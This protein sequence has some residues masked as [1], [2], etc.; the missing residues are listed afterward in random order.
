MKKQI[1][2]CVALFCASLTYAADI[3]LA[4]VDYNIDTIQRLI[5]GPGCEY[6]QT[7]M[8]QSSDGKK[9]LDV[10]FLFVDTHNPY[11]HMEQVLSYDKLIGTECPTA[12]LERK[13]TSTHVVVG[14]TNADFFVTGSAFDNGRPIGLTIGNSEYAYV[15]YSDYN[16]ELERRAAGVDV[17]G[18]GQFAATWDYTGSLVLSDT[19]LDIIRVNYYR[20]ENEL[21]LFNHHRGTS[22]E[23]NEYGTEVVAVLA[24]GEKWKTNGSVQLVVK[25]VRKN[26]GN[27]TLTKDQVVLSGHGTKAA[28][29]NTLKA[30]DKVVINFTLLFNGEGVDLAQCAGGDNYKLIVDNGTPVESKKGVDANGKEIELNFW[31]ELHPRTGFG[32][33][34]NRDTLVMC[35]VDGRTT[36]SI[37]CTTQVLGE[38]MRHYG[39][40]YALNWDGGGS[41][42]MAINHFGQV[43]YASSNGVERAVGNGMF[44]VADVPEDDQT[45][46]TL[47]PYETHF[48]VPPY[49]MY[50]PK[51][52]GYNK[53]GI[54]ISTDVKDVVLSCDESLGEIRNNNEFIASGTQSGILHATAGNGTA[55]IHISFIAEAE[56]AFRL[57]SVL[58]DDRKS[59]AV[60]VSSL[61]GSTT[62]KV[63]AHV[64]NWKSE[65]ENICTVNAEGEIVAVNN[66]V[67]TVVGMLGSFA[68][69]I[70]VRVQFPIARD[71]L[72]E[73]FVDNT[74]SWNIKASPASFAPTFVAPTEEN[75]FPSLQFTGKTTRSPYILLEKDIPLYGL[76]DSIRIRFSTDAVIEKFTLT[77]HANNQAESEFA[78]HIFEP[79]PTNVD[80]TLSIAISDL[81]D[82]AD[83]AIYPIWM[84]SLRFALSTKLA[85]G[86]YNIVWK[87]IELYYDG[88]A[89]LTDLDQATLPTWVV[90]PNPVADGVLQVSNLTVGAS[91]VLHD[92]QGRELVRQ[93]V[94]DEQMQLDMQAY[95]AGQYLLTINNQTVKIIKK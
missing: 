46:A 62:V 54:L 86:V 4:R 83:P 28:V 64:L 26:V 7:R 74:D 34:V 69:T 16:A 47:V 29:L 35:V 30:G 92:I 27:T 94:G 39:A 13:T 36:K 11:I 18:L 91:L 58:L 81:F 14:G 8:V 90:Y 41:S 76:P 44:V 57:D 56:V 89:I 5:V 40:W 60:E 67:T 95:P 78:T 85:A 23:T 88:V 1:L 3:T 66:G 63:A 45:I 51:F 37:G 70:Q 55:E 38:I 53:Y 20:G 50:T 17:N 84:K 31:N 22:T 6:L 73:D 59:Y 19:T 72:W 68:D 65:D 52:Y 9:P 93:T 82:G 71:Y 12:M 75:P 10:Y 48:S 24:E 42:C 15:G 21:V 87:G 49:G 2:L 79:I 77:L 43:N 32:A 33:T 25:E 61:I 80:T